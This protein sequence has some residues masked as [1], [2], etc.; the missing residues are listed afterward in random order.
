MGLG[1]TGQGIQI[2]LKP[3]PK[4]DTAGLGVKLDMG[5]AVSKRKPEPKLDAKQV[6]KLEMDK[7]RKGEK[8]SEMFYRNESIQKYMGE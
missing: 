3:K 2:P 6:R 5:R 4:Y 8:L 1:A 7:R